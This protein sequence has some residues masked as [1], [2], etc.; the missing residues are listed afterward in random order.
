MKKTVTFILTIIMI[1][2]MLVPS[3]AAENKDVLSF[4]DDGTFRIMNISDIQDGTKL[5]KTTAEFFKAVIAKEN[6]DLIVLTGDN[7]A[8]NTLSADETETAIRAVMDVFE[9]CGV[10]VAIVFGNHDEESGMCKEEQMA[11][12]NTYSCSV[13]VDEGE[14]LWGC[15]TYNIPVYSSDDDTDVVFNCWMFDSGNRD[16]DGEYDHV[17]EDQIE[18]YKTESAR[19]KAE[20][21][22]EPVPSIAFQHII[23]PEVFEAFDE[24][25]SSVK[26][27]VVKYGKY[28]ALPA[29]AAEGSVIGEPPCPSGTN[30][31]Q[32]D[33]FVQCGD[34]LAVVSGHDHTNSFSVEYKGID[35]INSPTAGLR[36][37]GDNS[38]RGVRMFIINEENP[39]DYETKVVTYPEVFEDNAQAMISF[40]FYGFFSEAQSFF[41]TLW[42]K[43][44]GL[45]S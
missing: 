45:F 38:S 29:S 1:I 44:T 3:F 27:S 35:I 18:W 4:N 19:L 15:G 25:D 31:G 7:I 12:Y 33:A 14:A 26:G 22:G 20:N 5:V 17:K 11:I 24:V 8:G 39:S 32:F 28:Y 6:P 30:G 43:V 13:S 41:Y 23:V 40:R 36:S 42:S 16:E 21:D 34:V 10:P 2:L 37:Y 9:E